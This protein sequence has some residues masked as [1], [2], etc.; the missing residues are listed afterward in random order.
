MGGA[1][2]G[3]GLERGDGGQVVHRHGAQLQMPVGQRV[4]HTRD[5][6][7]CGR[8]EP[9]ALALVL[10]GVRE[11]RVDGEHQRRVAGVEGLRGSGKRQALARGIPQG[12]VQNVFEACGLEA[13]AILLEPVAREGEPGRIPTRRPRG[14]A[15]VGLADGLGG[16]GAVGTSVIQ[17]VDAGVDLSTHGVV[18][19]GEKPAHTRLPRAPRRRVKNGDAM[20]GL[21]EAAREA[22]GRSNANT[23]AREAAGTAAN[24]N[25]VEVGHGMATVLQGRKGRGDELDVGLTATHVVARSKDVRDRA[26]LP[27]HHRACKHVGGRIDGKG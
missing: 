17:L 22:L 25:A 15:L 4:V 19:H 3:R 10:L 18:S 2:E 7:T 14:H 8:L 1:R 9:K 6:D 23:H 12:L 16:K 11:A 5:L 26:G 27:G 21:G 13:R 20:E 24:K